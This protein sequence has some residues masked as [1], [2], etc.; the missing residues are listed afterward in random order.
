[1]DNQYRTLNRE[2][3]RTRGARFQAEQALAKDP[4]NKELQ[5]KAKKA[6]YAFMDYLSGT[7]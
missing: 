7:K 1:M 6:T 4:E 3:I 2:F 5:A